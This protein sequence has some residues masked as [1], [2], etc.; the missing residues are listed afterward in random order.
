MDVSVTGV[1]VINHAVVEHKLEVVIIQLQNMVVKIAQ[2]QL[3]KHA[4]N[5][6]VQVNFI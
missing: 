5:R 3:V 2:V 6:L 4:I 1:N